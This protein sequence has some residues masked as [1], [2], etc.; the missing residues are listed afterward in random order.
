MDKDSSV[1]P[2]FLAEFQVTA[3]QAAGRGWIQVSESPDALDEIKNAIGDADKIGLLPKQQT[4]F[5]H[6]KNA[7][8][9]LVQLYILNFSQ[10]QKRIPDKSESHLA[11]SRSQ[12]HNKKKCL[13]HP[14][15]M[16]AILGPRPYE[17]EEQLALLLEGQGRTSMVS[18]CIKYHQR[19]SKIISNLI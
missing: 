9:F 6:Q 13:Q 17:A 7:G 3:G 11:F 1:P 14:S 19:S 16:R 4:S 15:L 5:W 18:K 12:D 8:L 2:G 10:K